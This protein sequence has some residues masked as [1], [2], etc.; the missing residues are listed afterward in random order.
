MI[1]HADLNDRKAFVKDT[2]EHLWTETRL[3]A[4]KL[5][6]EGETDLSRLTL[7]MRR[8]FG[9]EYHDAA[10]IKK[11]QDRDKDRKISGFIFDGQVVK[12]QSCSVNIYS[13]LVESLKNRYIVEKTQ[14]TKRIIELGAGWGKNLFKLWLYGAPVDAD[15]CS[16]ELTN[17]GRE[18]FRKIATHAAPKM[19]LKTFEFDYYNADFSALTENIPTVV[20]SHH[21]LEQITNIPQDLMERIAK[22]P[23]LTDV[24]HLEPVGFQWQDD[25]WLAQK[26]LNLM[27]Q[28]D[29]GNK[30]F[31]EKRQQ[32]LDLYD[33]LSDLEKKGK[34]QITEKKKYY[35]STILNNA[36]S[37]LS[38]KPI[39]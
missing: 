39:L 32:N 24:L 23:G 16:Y 28:I 25:S 18:L 35:C 10:L 31:A 8:D 36:T 33:V 9:P 27:A 14:N 22:I 15:Y 30:K 19:N 12:P 7:L 38:W 37:I 17:S 4:E 21:S 5:I 2:Y 13:L 29:S 34:I 1:S 26:D 3:K 20:F 6:A 11:N